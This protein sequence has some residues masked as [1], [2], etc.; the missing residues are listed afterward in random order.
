MS[1]EEKTRSEEVEDFK[2]NIEGIL[3]EKDEV[4]KMAQQSIEDSKAICVDMDK[5]QDTLQNEKIIADSLTE[6]VVGGIS[7]EDWRGMRTQFAQTANAHK[8]MSSLR[9]DM[10][11]ARLQTQQF[12]FI[13]NTILSSNATT[14]VSATFIMGPYAQ[15]YPPV[16]KAIATVKISST[17]TQDI[18]FI[19][20][21]LKKI[22]PD[23]SKAFESV[24]ADMSG[25]G[26]RN[27][28]HRA[29]LAL[30][31]VIFNQLLDKIA[32]EALYSLTKW[33]KITPPGVPFR[34]MRFCQTKFFIF[35]S[36]DETAFAQSMID[37]VNK[38]SFEMAAHFDDMSEYGKKGAS[39]ILVDNCYRQTVTSFANC[40]KL[41]TQFQ[42]QP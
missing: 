7:N 29:L 17:L 14:S 23:V 21:E 6:D 38:A 41:R 36:N 28:K 20:V 13:S 35:G 25:T 10:E 11:G 9:R 40:M 1:E 18:D 24:V 33:F 32:P 26:D 2:H 3:K 19:R 27:L 30:R 22:V 15:H 16:S 34:K 42:K 12:R 31:S 39:D 4:K 8:G 5:L 37:A